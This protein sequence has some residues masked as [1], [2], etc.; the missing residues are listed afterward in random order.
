MHSALRH[1]ET[2]ITYELHYSRRKTVGIAVHRDRRV[3]V[4]APVGSDPA[5]V[6]AIVHARAGWIARQ[7]QQF[8]QT[9]P[10]P[11]P[12]YVSGEPH[13]HLGRAYPLEL[14]HGRPMSVALAGERLVVTLPDQGGPEAVRRALARWRQS[15]AARIFPERLSACHR[16]A[17]W[18]AVP[19]P[20]LRLRVMRSRWGT[21]NAR[22]MITL[23]TRLIQAPI[24][25]IDYVILHELCHLRELNHSA[26]YYALLE[27]VLPDWRERRKQL[28]AYPID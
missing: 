9:A 16:H 10:T 17:I 27:Q 4:T 14:C 24:E 11:T 26:R 5:A 28:N 6:Q 25:C 23:N 19:H 2:T 12:R 13:H 21:C 3:I 1:G 8:A 18:L 7:L 15:E 20:Q 22:G